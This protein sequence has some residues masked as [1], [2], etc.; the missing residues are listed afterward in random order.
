MAKVVNEKWKSEMRSAILQC[1]E[2]DQTISFR[3]ALQWLITRLSDVGVPYKLFNLGA[4][5]TRI[6]TKTDVCPCCKR[7]L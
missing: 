2:I 1:K 7:T 3:A 5:V 4:G 6:T